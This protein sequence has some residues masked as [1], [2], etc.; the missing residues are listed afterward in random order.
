[1]NADNVYHAN[2]ILGKMHRIETIL[3]LVLEILYK[4]I[5]AL[6]ALGVLRFLCVVFLLK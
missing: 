3:K 5:D 2:V 6:I 4:T 1:V